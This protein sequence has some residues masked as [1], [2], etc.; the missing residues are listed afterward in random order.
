MNCLFVMLV[1]ATLPKGFWY[2]PTW[3]NTRPVQYAICAT[4]PERIRQVGHAL[5]HI[6]SPYVD[7]EELNVFLS[8]IVPLSIICVTFCTRAVKLSV[9]LSRIPPRIGAACDAA[10]LTFLRWFDEMVSRVKSPVLQH[11]LVHSIEPSMLALLLSAELH[12]DY[13]TCMLSEVCMELP[14]ATLRD[15]DKQKLV[16][17]LSSIGWVTRRAD[18]IRLHRWAS[19]SQDQW[20][21]GQILP[22]ALLIYPLVSLSETILPLFLKTYTAGKL[23]QPTP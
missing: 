11:Y 1:V 23:S 14:V 13:L 18:N 16:F 15:T 5:S 4:T 21:F 10:S 7:S 20:T 2:G 6:N 8:M 9:R 19:G 12:R 3:M 17:A 22:L